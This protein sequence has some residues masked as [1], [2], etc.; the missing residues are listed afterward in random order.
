MRRGDAV[1]RARGETTRERG[2][3]APSRPSRST[4]ASPRAAHSASSA[5][6]GG[7]TPKGTWQRSPKSERSRASSEGLSRDSGLSTSRRVSASGGSRLA[8]CASRAR[9]CPLSRR[10]R[11]GAR[12]ARAA[13]SPTPLRPETRRPNAGNPLALAHPPGTRPRV[14][15]PPPRTHAA[16]SPSPSRGR[17][18][19]SSVPSSFATRGAFPSTG[20]PRWPLPP[21]PTTRDPP[22]VPTRPDPRDDPPD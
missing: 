19:R 1:G 11:R 5:R 16:A 15:R 18:G 6:V 2:W 12:V 3:Y 7:A 20:A 4:R 14:R 9:A 21:F 17:S 8:H 10:C 22:R 13:P